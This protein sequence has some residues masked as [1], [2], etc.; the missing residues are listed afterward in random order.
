MRAADPPKRQRPVSVRAGA[1]TTSLNLIAQLD[2]AVGPNTVWFAIRR[3]YL[4]A[5]GAARTVGCATLAARLFSAR[6]IP[7][8]LGHWHSEVWVS[9]S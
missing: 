3:P 9:A 6:T 1:R 2:G 5:T 8:C 7:G 4:G